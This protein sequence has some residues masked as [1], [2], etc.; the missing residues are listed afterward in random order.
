MRKFLLLSSKFLK[1]TSQ[2]QGTFFPLP[3]VFP[4]D[5]K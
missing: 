5:M 2:E 4:Y 3:T 1:A